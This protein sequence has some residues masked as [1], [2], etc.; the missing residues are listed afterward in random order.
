[1]ARVILLSFL[2]LFLLL[3]TVLW[4]VGERGRLLLPSTWKGLCNG[5]IKRVLNFQA[6]HMYVYGRWT[7]GYISLLR[8]QIIPRIGERGRK[9]WRDRYH[10]K[11]LTTELAEAVI[12]VDEDIPL[13]D[14]EHI[15]PYPLARDLVLNGPPDVAAYECGCRGSSPNPCLPTQV[16]LVVGQPFVDFVLEHHPQGSRRLT[17][18]EALK[19]LRGEHERG[20]LHTAWFKDAMLDRFYAICNCCKCCCAGIEIMMK[21]GSP[22]I[23]SSGYVAETDVSMCDACGTCI[24]FCPFE[25]LSVDG[26]CIVNRD[27]CM[28]CGVCVGQCPSEA[29]TLSLDERKG[30][31]LDVRAIG[32]GVRPFIKDAA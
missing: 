29:I 8:S 32:G 3:M 30:E 6:L 20:H 11:I 14:L 26:E 1:M 4:I 21:Y 22:M 9:W 24:N 25:A 18:T 15:I 27:K 7:D 5:G 28:G 17:Q 23:A 10:G 31:P 16:C 19:L 13:Q 12:M 2:G